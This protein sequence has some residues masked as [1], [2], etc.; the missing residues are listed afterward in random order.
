MRSRSSR[1]H[2]DLAPKDWSADSLVRA[3]PAFQEARADKAVR[4]PIGSANLRT[5]VGRFVSLLTL[6]IASAV[7]GL[8]GHAATVL[9]EAE[10]FRN[11]GG[12]LIDPQFM[13]QMGSPY[14]LAH[15][16]GVPVK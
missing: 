3:T 12:W 15:G 5:S 2:S 7:A 11:T 4:A 14:L 13:D 9:V 10:N 8:P 16:L 6:S 1:R